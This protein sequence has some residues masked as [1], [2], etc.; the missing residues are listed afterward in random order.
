MAFEDSPR[1][2]GSLLDALINDL[3][4]QRQLDEARTIEAWAYIAGPHINA[5]TEKVWVRGD[6]LF[7][8]VTRAAWR[9]ELHHARKRWRD[10]LNQHLGA[11]LVREII[12]R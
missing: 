7:V 12:F 5:V 3:G 1:R 11:P 9:H 6:Q 10:R 2:L 4:I 8:K